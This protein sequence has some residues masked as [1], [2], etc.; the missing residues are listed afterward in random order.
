MKQSIY[1]AG[2]MR[3]Y[4]AFN[5]PAFDEATKWLRRLG[6]EVC[7]PA[8]HD[9]DVYGE[10]TP[11]NA[12]G[13]G[14][15]LR[16]ALAFDLDWIA[17][18]ADAVAVLDGWEE[19]NGANAEVALAHALGIPVVPWYHIGYT[20]DIAQTTNR[21]EPTKL[22]Q[23]RVLYVQE[24]PTPPQGV[25]YGDLR[26]LDLDAEQFADRALATH[27]EIRTTSQTGGDKGVK[28]A[29]FDLLPTYPLEQIAEHFGR[30]ASKYAAHNWRRGYEL[31]KSYAAL[32]RHAWS[33]WAGNEV[34]ADGWPHLA[35]VGFHALALLQLLHD[36]EEGRLPAEFDDRYQRTGVRQ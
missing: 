14:F 29:R 7:N 11:E 25:L 31:S 9:R 17:R 36:I 27:G 26:A 6:Y 3:G 34:D 10:I 35:A 1:V 19:S 28:P 30:G 22:G 15:D 18:N 20:L 21:I 12:E 24:L 4:E 2:P 13:K 32:Q 33:W 23:S 5:F 8:E 16:A